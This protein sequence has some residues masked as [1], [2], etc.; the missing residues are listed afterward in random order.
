MLNLKIRNALPVQENFLGNGAVYHGFAGM[1]DA[2]DRVYSDEQCKIEA[3]RAADMR[4]KVVRTKYDWWAWDKDTNTWNWDNDIMRPFYKWLKRMKDANIDV[5]LNTGWNSPGDILSNSWNGK[6]PFTVEG[7]WEA[8]VRKFGD[9]VSESVYQIVELRGFTNVKYLTLFTEPQH[10]GS[11]GEPCDPSQTPY[12]C[13]F[14]AAKAAHDALVRDGRRDLV[15]I[16]GPNEGATITSDMVKWVSDRNPDFVDIYSSHNYQFSPPSP[17]KLLKEGDSVISSSIAGGRGMCP[18]R[19]NPKTEYICK[20]DF[21]VE[22][23]S[24]KCDEPI[25]GAL[26]YGVF[27][28]SETCDIYDDGEL[29][30]LRSGI[31]KN[32]INSIAGDLI[33]PGKQSY[34]FKFTTEYSTRG[35]LGVFFDILDSHNVYI[36]NLNI[37]DN[38]GESVVKNP[39]LHNRHKGW[40]IKYADG[41]NQS[42]DDWYEWAKTGLQYVPDSKGFCFDEYNVVYNRDNSRDSMGAEIVTAAMGLMNAGVQLS[43]VWTVF[44]QLWPNSSTT[45]NDSFFDGE[46][47]CGFM[48]TLFKSLIPHKAYYAF[49][50][51]SR[52]ITGEG[53]KI[54]EGDFILRT[55]VT[56]SVSPDGDITIVVVNEKPEKEEFNIE[57]EQAL[58]DVKFYRHIFNPET[59][60][61]DEKAEMIGVDKVTEPI[62]KFLTDTISAYGVIVYTTIKD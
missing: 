1:P 52:Y 53:T 33:K 41:V 22:K 46:H 3:K 20:I 7:D 55:G 17:Y 18:V 62:T 39:G 26:S 45:N 38:N 40:N 47:R 16:I 42:Y 57:F 60:I 44:D 37:I 56:M 61:P 12:T 6:S 50:L 19:L 15:K 30:A 14:D 43:F 25:R 23:N 31:C 32:S 48:P 5:S 24:I 34:S 29:D 10:F 51:L 8:S 27:E 28:F 54:Y 59:C 35:L 49:G 2:S 4:L 9:W 36:T 13:W 58:N 11:N 21:F